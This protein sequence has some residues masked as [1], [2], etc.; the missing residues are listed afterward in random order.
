MVPD[1]QAAPRR[2]HRFAFGVRRIS[3]CPAKFDS[4]AQ[5]RADKRGEDVLM[6]AS[7][8][9]RSQGPAPHSQGIHHGRSG[10]QPA[11]LQTATSSSELQRAGVLNITTAEGDTVSIS[12]AGLQRSQSES[13]SARTSNRTAAGYSASSSA[14]LAIE[15]KV[16]GSLSQQEMSDIGTLMEALG[17]AVSDARNG[18]SAKLMSDLESTYSLGSLQAFGFGYQETAQIQSRA[19]TSMVA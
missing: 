4:A 18:D 9:S 13:Y 2:R 7:I 19:T 3:A 14:A 1:R 15:V 6:T 8:E 17:A 10:R 5:V 16:D 12:F 11:R